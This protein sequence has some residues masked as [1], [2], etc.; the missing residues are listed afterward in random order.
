MIANLNNFISKLTSL[1][2]VTKLGELQIRISPDLTKFNLIA[3]NLIYTLLNHLE[4]E[5]FIFIEGL[6]YCLMPQADDHIIYNTKKGVFYSRQKV[7]LGC[8]YCDSCPGW[9]KNITNKG[10]T[11]LAIPDLP[12]EI[13]V[14][15]TQDCNQNCLLCFSARKKKEVPISKVKEIIRDCRKLGIKTVRFSGGEPLL[16]SHLEEALTF[17]KKNGLYVLLNTNA[18][19]LGKKDIQYIK[20]LVDNVLVSLQGWDI[21]SERKLTRTNRKFKEKLLNIITLTRYIPT[22]RIGTIISRTLINEWPRL[23]TL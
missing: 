5:Y 19:I 13:V 1:G 10:I 15:V 8:K 9:P 21:D 12:K 11:P 18:T 14:E 7:C 23:G 20:K 6:P 16:Y 17:A 2:I 4:K 3:R 22:V